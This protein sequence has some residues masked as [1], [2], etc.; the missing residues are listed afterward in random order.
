MQKTN[1][2]FF[3]STRTD[4]VGGDGVGV[5]GVGGAVVVITAAP[6]ALAELPLSSIYS[7]DSDGTAG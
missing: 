2:H 1:T 3:P 7:E 6:P 4:R 5:L